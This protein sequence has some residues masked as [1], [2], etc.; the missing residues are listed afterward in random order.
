M[1]RVNGV[2]F[3]DDPSVESICRRVVAAG[4][5]SLEVSRP[6]FYEQLITPEV[7]RRFVAFTEEIG[8]S[9]YG[10]DCWVDVDPYLE[11][12]QTVEDFAAAIRWADELDLGMIISH[13]PWAKDNGDRK[14]STCLEACVELFQRV[15]DLC[16]ARNLR[17]VFEPHPDT[18]SMENAWATDFIDRLADGR[19]PH[20]V[21]ILYDSC[22]YGIGQPDSYVDSIV[23]LGS[24]IEHFHFSDGD[25]KTYALHLPLGDGELDLEGIV[26]A[27]AGIGYAGTFTNDLYSY[28]LVD[29][30][31]RRNAPKIREIEQRLGI[32]EPGGI[33]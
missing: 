8:L 19:P 4:F 11:T 20:S 13:D 17:L 27:L 28:P 23:A 1:A 10:F 5:D 3:R 7:R 12:G 21:G 14:P 26:S 24:R 6:P 32:G 15:A 25:R 9:L 18:L 16:A 30:G 31:A 2:S 29:D 33:A 22:H